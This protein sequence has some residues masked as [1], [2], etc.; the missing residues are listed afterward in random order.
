MR[1]L[2]STLFTFLLLHS[3]CAYSFDTDT[4]DKNYLNL[5]MKDLALSGV[6]EERQSIGRAPASIS[7][8]IRPVFFYGVCVSDSGRMIPLRNKDYLNCVNNEVEG[9]I[10]S[11]RSSHKF[12]GI[13]IPINP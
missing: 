10:G 2:Y 12:I 6:G 4:D 11:Y 9:S 3:K 5:K 8:P 7:H 13:T 1:H